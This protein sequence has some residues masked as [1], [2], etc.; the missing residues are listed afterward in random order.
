MRRLAISI[1]LPVLAVMAAHSLAEASDNRIE[2]KVL[3]VDPI[4]K[5]LTL[6]PMPPIPSLDSVTFVALEDTTNGQERTVVSM[7]DEDRQWLDIRKGMGCLVRYRSQYIWREEAKDSTHVHPATRIVLAQG[8]KRT[9]PTNPHTMDFSVLEA[10]VNSR[11]SEKKYAL[12][13]QNADEYLQAF[14]HKSLIVRAPSGSNAEEYVFYAK[15]L[16][17]VELKDQ[18]CWRGA[19]GDALGR[20]PKGKYSQ[21]LKKLEEQQRAAAPAAGTSRSGSGAGTATQEDS[22]APAMAALDAQQAAGSMT[23]EQFL[24]LKAKMYMAARRT[25]PAVALFQKLIKN[26]EANGQRMADLSRLLAMT[27]EQAGRKAEARK[28]L[29]RVKERHPAAFGKAGLAADMSRLSQ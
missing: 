13:V 7:M 26:N 28:A 18:P 20:Y 24:E 19:V 10:S 29:Q 15:A 9:D 6:S 2:G 14:F 5:I 16:A 23:E 1:V 27:F 3:S 11:L 22:L 4:A 8:T 12:L 17:C 25:E 21:K